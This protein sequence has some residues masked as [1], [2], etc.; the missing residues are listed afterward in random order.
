MI[1]A[2][3]HPGRLAKRICHNLASLDTCRLAPVAVAQDI[4]HPVSQA[5]GV[6]HLS[7]KQ[8]HDLL[9]IASVA[10][11]RQIKFNAFHMNCAGH[12]SP[13][14]WTH[15]RDRSYQ[16]T[17]IEY[18]TEL[19]QILE[20]GKFES[21]FLADVLGAYDVYQGSPD[22]AFRQG[23]QIPVN[24]PLFLIPIM[25]QATRHLGF[26][27]TCSVIYE[28]PYSFARR[29]STLDHLTK[30]RVGWN[31]VSSF[32]DSAARNFGMKGQIDHDERYDIADE[33]MEV[34]Y[35]LWEGSWEQD[36]V[37][38]DRKQRLFSDPRK[39]HDI[40]HHGRYYTVPGFHL[41]EPSPQRTPVLF[42]AGSSRRGSEFAARHA[43]C[44]FIGGPSKIYLKNYIERVRN[45]A[46]EFGRN[47]EDVLF[48]KGQSVVVA[49]TE[50][51]AKAKYAE[52]REHVSYDG[53]LALVSGWTGIDFGKYQPDDE[54]RD[55]GTN[56]GQGTL[57]FLTNAD[58]TKR[59]TLREMA[60]WIGVGG[61]AI[62][63]SP[64]QVADSM[65]EWVEETGL[66]GFNL[67]FALAHDSFS[68]L[69]DLVV[70]ELQRRGVYRENYGSGT[71][72]ENLFNQ[73][74]HL[75]ETHPAAVFRHLDA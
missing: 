27:A 9:L 53:T 28:H 71:L 3:E 21:I 47:P 10:M 15:P 60:D 42:Q 59:W 45:R 41:S 57:E 12:Q 35:K 63:G 14:L 39:V 50:A 25:A 34:C 44:I 2:R 55:V 66:D 48:F 31:I 73:S 7:P 62:V 72:R 32:L 23:L 37:V 61:G 74:G 22:H 13:G 36:A 6:N 65:Q 40:N 38:R 1:G 17:D 26:A 5:C 56:A 11:A 49:E 20:R 67:S 64:E 33:Y 52:L 68:D 70:P 51:K 18:W 4:A 24:D 69:V 75:P 54:L 29:M 16:Y 58:P 30:G 46:A 43:E 8:V 19:A